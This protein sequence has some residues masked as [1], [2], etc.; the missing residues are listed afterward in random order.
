MCS[1]VGRARSLYLRGP[2]F[3]SWRTH[4][5]EVNEVGN[6]LCL[7]KDEKTLSKSHGDFGEYDTK[8]VQLL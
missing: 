8:G 5:N 1:S 7:F 3:E 6:K 2:R 4:M